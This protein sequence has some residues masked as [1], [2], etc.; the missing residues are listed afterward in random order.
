[1]YIYMYIY[2]YICK[3]TQTNPSSELKNPGPGNVF[4]NYDTECSK[5][6]PSQLL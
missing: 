3:F 4:S 6:Y 1:M 2:I 5:H